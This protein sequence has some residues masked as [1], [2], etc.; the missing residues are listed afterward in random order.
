[1]IKDRTSRRR[2]RESRIRSRRRDKGSRGS[3][4]STT[5]SRRRSTR[6]QEEAEPAGLT[7][8]EVEAGGGLREAKTAEEVAVTKAGTQQEDKRKLNQ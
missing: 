8:T 3:R 6:E 1:M 5:K 2:T 4:K 7:I